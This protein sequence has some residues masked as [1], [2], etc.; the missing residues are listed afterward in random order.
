MDGHGPRK[1][2]T[3]QHVLADLSI[4]HLERCIFRCGYAR[5]LTHG[6]DYGLDLFMWTCATDG[7][8]DN[9]EVKFQVKAT[10]RP[11]VLA[12]GVTISFPVETRDL[13]HWIKEEIPVIL[14]VYDGTKDRGY[15]LD[16]KGYARERG[17]HL[18][19]FTTEKVSLRIPMAS[20]L[21]VRSVRRMRQLLLRMRGEE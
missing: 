15:W 8:M 11:T 20:R 6:S 9:G 7:Q 21:T 3:R 4:N 5:I 18:R 19:A 13:N 10:D 12:D 1:Q 17:W 2:R 14:V 16:V